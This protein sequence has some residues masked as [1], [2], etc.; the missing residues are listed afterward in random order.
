[1]ASHG[2]PRTAAVERT[3]QVKQK[4]LQQIDQYNELVRLVNTKVSE[5]QYSTETLAL[6]SKL[7]TQNPEYYTI[8]NYRRL[9]LQDTFKNALAEP[10]IEPAALSPGQQIILD[11]IVNDLRFLVPLLL[12]FPKCY[13]IWN[14]RLWLLEQSTGQLPASHARRLWQEELGLVGK[15]L[16]RDSRNFHGWS[17]RRIVVAHLEQLPAAETDQEAERSGTSMTEPEFAYTTKMINTNL[18]NFSAWH[19]RSKLIPRLLAERNA[20]ESARRAFLAAEFEFIQRALYTDPYDQSLWFYHAYLMNTVDPDTPPEARICLDLD[21]GLPKETYD[22][23][24]ESIKDMM[25]GA[26]DCKWIYQA[27]LQ[28]AL[29]L[30]AVSPDSVSEDEMAAWLAELRKLD[31]LRSERWDDLS[32]KLNI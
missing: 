12:K 32:K 13:W 15:M 4:E 17:Y 31:P 7:L 24:L 26:E 22:E 5:E 8:W 6:V 30:K 14:H 21:S 9:I 18:S 10:A 28:C 20:D 27:L 23:Q 3:E 29:A 1:M 16:N 2:V 19:N 25:D 11:Y